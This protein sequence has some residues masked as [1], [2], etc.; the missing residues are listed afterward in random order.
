MT[1]SEYMEKLEEKLQRFSREL[2]EEILE[3][4]RQHFAEG[5]KQGRSVGDI[6]QELGDIDEMIR[7]LS[8]VSV[9]RDGAE[10]PAEAKASAEV[11]QS[12]R[13]GE[14]YRAMKLDCDVAS[15]VLEPSEDGAI[16]VE[17][18]N[19]A[20]GSA[21][22]VFSYYQYEE[23]GVF[24]AGVKKVKE[25]KMQLF[26]RSATVTFEYNFSMPGTKEESIVLTVKVPKG[27]P[28]LSFSTSSG[29]AR[30]AGLRVDN[31][32][33][34]TASGSLRATGVSA[35]KL[36][37]STASGRIAVS[38]VKTATAKFSTASGRMTVTQVQAGELDCESASGHI[39]VDADSENCRFSNVSGKS[40]L[41]LTG[42][43]KKI[44]LNTVSGVAALEL[45]KTEGIETMIHTV[46]GVT[47][48]KWK[49]ERHTKM[50]NG[51]VGT[52]TAKSRWIP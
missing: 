33:G 1:K 35:G 32:Q 38:E 34:A 17:Y 6:I 8:E 9:G 23:D 31:L 42:E 2:Q 49:E 50:K 39:A 48:I 36:K 41:K 40:E 51:S 25:K 18:R 28:A 15:V 3:D 21:G 4:Y 24:Y 45:G 19:G 22:K 37:L 7:E 43:T 26:G 44:E 46:S 10:D 47:D 11:H 5:E 13:Y 52:E 20:E 29:N 14:A 27:M 16:Q 30:A 12:Y